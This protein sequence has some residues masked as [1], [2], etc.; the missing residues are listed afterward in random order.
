MIYH[1]YY[2]KKQQLLKTTQKPPTKHRGHNRFAKKTKH[3]YTQE[4]LDRTCVFLY[5]TIT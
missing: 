4:N 2:T 3:T 5:H 1:P